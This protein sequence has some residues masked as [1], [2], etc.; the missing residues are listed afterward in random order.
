MS[1]DIESINI[2]GQTFTDKR[3]TQGALTHVSKIN[4]TEFKKDNTDEYDGMFVDTK[5]DMNLKTDSESALKKNKIDE[6]IAAVKFMSRYLSEHSAQDKTIEYYT[7]SQTKS[8]INKAVATD[9]I[10]RYSS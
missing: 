6:A 9:I 8:K 5:D 2:L 1:Q 3:R 4:K 7:T 10:N